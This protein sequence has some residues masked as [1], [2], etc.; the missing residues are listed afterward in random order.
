MVRALWCIPIALLTA[1]LTAMPAEPPNLMLALETQEKLVAEQPSNA[2]AHN[3]LGNLLVAAKRLDEAETAYKTALT[4]APEDPAVRF[5]LAVFYQQTGRRKKAQEQYQK[6]LDLDTRNAWA[7]YQ[8]GALLEARGQRGEA[9]DHYA[10]AFA[11]DDGLTFA[12]NNPHLIENQL[13]TEA[14][15]QARRYREQPHTQVPR[16]YADSARIRSLFLQGDAPAEV[17]AESGPGAAASAARVSAA[18]ADALHA[19]PPARSAG[20][21]LTPQDLRESRAGQVAVGGTT[22]KRG[23]GSPGYRPA[24]PATGGP[25]YRRPV[26]PPL[27]ASRA[28]AAPQ[29]PVTGRQLEGAA[30]G[31]NSAEGIALGESAGVIP[32]PNPATPPVASPPVVSPTAR[33]GAPIVSPQP[34][35]VARPSRRSTSQLELQLLPEQTTQERY[36]QLTFQPR[37]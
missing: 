29:A 7:H 17:P 28:G 27:P 32:R 20:R 35:G 14:L 18:E 26:T 4:L 19:E 23:A 6:L 3:D 12:N 21:A 22:A 33:P 34:G 10:R 25:Q 16:Q 11:Y 1:A 5:N 24:A 15:L 8:L 30:L 31:E 37:G 13:V 9:I 2:K 36:A